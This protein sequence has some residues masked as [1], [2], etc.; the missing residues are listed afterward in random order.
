[1]VVYR[2]LNNT[3]IAVAKLHLRNNQERIV[4]VR[5][6]Q[7]WKH[8]K[9]LVFYAKNH[10]PV[11]LICPVGSVLWSPFHGSQTHKGRVFSDKELKKAEQNWHDI[12]WVAVDG[13]L[14]K[15][16]DTYLGLL[17]DYLQ[18]EEEDFD[19]SSCDWSSIK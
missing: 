2:R 15:I 7:G 9:H 13:N 4:R 3:K 10:T 11:Y 19:S 18:D 6:T 1:V 17:Y 16:N 12:G 14:I 5:K 8:I